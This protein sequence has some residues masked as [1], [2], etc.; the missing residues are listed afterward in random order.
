MKKFFFALIGI[1]FFSTKS[2]ATECRDKTF[3]F[4]DS[5]IPSR[6]LSQC[7]KQINADYNYGYVENKADID[8]SAAISMKTHSFGVSTTVKTT[9]LDSVVLGSFERDDAE[10]KNSSK[11][12]HNIF[13]FGVS[14]PFLDDFGA[15]ILFVGANEN[16]DYS[17]SSDEFEKN[18]STQSQSIFVPRISLSGVFLPHWQLHLGYQWEVEDKKKNES[19]S[20]YTIIA[21]A[22]A[23]IAVDGVLTE[24]ISLFSSLDYVWY[25]EEVSEVF[26]Y[27][28]SSRVGAEVGLAMIAIPETLSFF[29]S[30][31]YTGT[32]A[33]SDSSVSGFNRV[34][35]FANLWQLQIKSTYSVLENLDVDFTLGGGFGSQKAKISASDDTSKSS[36]KFKSKS[37]RGGLGLR[38]LF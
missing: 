16:R 19:E 7:H 10:W 24:G 21:P 9:F 36:F 2:F 1:I 18:N 11:I 22:R 3:R 26:S 32:Y 8:S 30:L 20:D 25:S 35:A 5:F 17:N 4:P 12:K 29:P 31:S 23:I 14:T 6:I 13:T 15:G 37:Y 34:Y 33:M 28:F 27:E 38:Y